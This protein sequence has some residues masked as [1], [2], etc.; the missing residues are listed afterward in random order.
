MKIVIQF[1]MNT[2]TRKKVPV[3]V[4]RACPVCVPA[5]PGVFLP[6]LVC[7]NCRSTDPFSKGHTKQTRHS[8]SETLFPTIIRKTSI[9]NGDA[10]RG[11]DPAQ[12]I[13]VKR[14][15]GDKQGK[16]GMSSY[17]TVPQGLYR[18]RFTGRS[19]GC[20]VAR[21]VWM[22]VR[23]VCVI[24]VVVRVCRWVIGWL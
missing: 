24:R 9:S 12:T 5:P 1:H 15:R 22:V 16:H 19:C 10:S 20:V 21:W 11:A 14:H 7:R 6:V 8:Q 3:R 23:F 17:S 4:S 18:Y 2:P 13:P